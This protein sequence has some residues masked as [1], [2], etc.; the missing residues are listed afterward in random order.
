MFTPRKFPI[1]ITS[2]ILQMR[3]CV[4]STDFSKNR[5]LLCTEAVDD[6]RLG[7]ILRTLVKTNKLQQA[8]ERDKTNLIT[9]QHGFRYKAVCVG[10]QT[11][12]H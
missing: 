12:I 11:L 8:R 4:T 10:E 9:P 5:F 2:I 3:A 1:H 7:V 6:M